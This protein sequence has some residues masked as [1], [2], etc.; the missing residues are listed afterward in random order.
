MIEKKFDSAFEAIAE[1]ILGKAVW[2]QIKQNAE[3]ACQQNSALEMIGGMRH[4]ATQIKKSLSKM[5]KPCRIHLMGHSAGSIILGHFARDLARFTDI[6]S[7][8]L[9][10]PACT[11]KFAN[12]TFRPLVEA[13][14]L[15]ANKF[16]IFNLSREN[17]RSD[18]I[19]PY[20]KS[21]LYLVSR[22][23]EMP[24]KSPLLG[25]DDAWILEAE[26]SQGKSSFPKISKTLVADNDR[27]RMAVFENLK[28]YYALQGNRASK[29]NWSVKEIRRLRGLRDVV[30]WREF[31]VKWKCKYMLHQGEYVRVSHLDNRKSYEPSSHGTLDNDITL[32]NT[33]I[34]YMIGSTPEPITDLRGT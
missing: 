31:M 3:A 7:I 10:A 19:G 33:A 13:R 27:H 11:L 30:D 4:L 5:K 16:Y 6:G 1:K 23:F 34:T 25:L 32:M 21:L 12:A 14:K 20:N 8:G 9:L 2:S 17:E 29:A 15:P 22:A 24:R 18:S 28:D 26:L